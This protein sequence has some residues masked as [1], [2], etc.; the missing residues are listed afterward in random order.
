[1]AKDFNNINFNN[2]KDLNIFWDAMEKSVEGVDNMSKLHTDYPI[3]NREEF[4]DYFTNIADFLHYVREEYTH[5][6]DDYRYTLFMDQDSNI[7]IEEEPINDLVLFFNTTTTVYQIDESW[8]YIAM[9]WFD[10]VCGYSI[11]NM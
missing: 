9:D 7:V 10:T 4:A 2:P 6:Q 8:R 11:W 1:M 5:E 3:N